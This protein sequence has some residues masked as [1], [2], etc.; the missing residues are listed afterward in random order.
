MTKLIRE[1]VDVAHKD[2]DIGIEIEMEAANDRPFPIMDVPHAVYWTSTRDGSLRGNAIEYVLRRP[3]P[4]GEVDKALNLLSEGLEKAGIKIRY[5][6]RAGAHVHINVQD[7]TVEQLRS[8]TALWMFFE[9]LLV[10]WCGDD[11]VGNLFCLRTCDADFLIDEVAEAFVTRDF[12]RLDSDNIRYASMNFK[13][14]PRYGSVEFRSLATDPKLDR[15]SQW[16]HVLYHLKKYAMGLDNPMRLF[17]DFSMRGEREFAQEI[18]EE[19][20]DMVKDNKN[21]EQQI[22]T[23]MRLAQEFT[24]FS[25]GK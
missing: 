2:G 10:D 16:A 3:I 13:A 11:R 18:L 19:Y 17:E 25:G 5:T 7:M 15:I 22:W 9:E 23:G 8:Y 4:I 12:Y 1:V 14:I 24:Y 20:Y 21:F 6:F